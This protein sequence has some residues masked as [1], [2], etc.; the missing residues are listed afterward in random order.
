MEILPEQSSDLKVANRRL[1][2]WE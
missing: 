1:R 2:L